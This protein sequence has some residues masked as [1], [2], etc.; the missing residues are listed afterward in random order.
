[1]LYICECK[2]VVLINDLLVF[3]VYV[4]AAYT[5]V[6]VLNVKNN[7]PLSD[8]KNVIEDLVYIAW[9]GSKHKCDAVQRITLL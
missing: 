4:E 2:I 7:I 6:I 9:P 1:M 8:G 3:N 5:Y